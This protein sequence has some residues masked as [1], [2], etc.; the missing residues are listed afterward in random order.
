MAFEAITFCVS[1]AGISLYKYAKYKKQEKERKQSF[2][3][4]MRE[5]E[6]E[7]NKEAE[8]IKNSDKYNP[9]YYRYKINEGEDI[10]Y[11][12]LREE[13]VKLEKIYCCI[14]HENMSKETKAKKHDEYMSE[15]YTHL[16]ILK[17]ELAQYKAY[18]C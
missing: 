14:C 6:E 3:K 4:F 5:V 2:D 17:E 18:F 10:T 9:E 16:E 12:Q 7:A 1:F 8:K 11:E 15:F 13:S